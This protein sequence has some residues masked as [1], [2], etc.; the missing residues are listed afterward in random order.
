MPQ[1]ILASGSPRRKELLEQV[2]YSFS[3]KTSP[4][5]E[6]IDRTLSP[7][8]IVQHVA[9]RKAKA[10]WKRHKEMVVLGADTL[11]VHENTVLGK[12]KSEEEA[13]RMLRLLSGS[14]HSVYTGVSIQSP[15]RNISF[16]E[17]T[18]VKFFTLDEQDIEMYIRSEEPFD[19]AGAYGIQGL[20]AYLIKKITGDYY[21]VVGLPL[22][23][24][25]RA[26]KSVGI[27]PN[28]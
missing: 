1:F 16:F 25:M 15:T 5:I 6:R 28:I 2:H 19:K 24:T 22:A 23:H 26:L 10:V 13:K 21:S 12:P 18:N 7:E 9:T 4:V 14:T 20:G 17:K 27:L 8:E 3:I 11:A